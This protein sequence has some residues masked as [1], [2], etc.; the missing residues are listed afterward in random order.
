MN[1]HVLIG[2]EA[3][4]ALLDEVSESTT[5]EL[6]AVYG[7]RRVGKTYL[8]RNYLKPSISFEFSGIHNVTTELQLERFAK[9][10]S[11]QLNNNIPIGVLPDWFTA[12]ELFAKLFKKKLRKRTVMFLD[13][14]PWMQTAKSNFL[15]AFENFW[16]TW[17]V[18]QNNLIVVICGSAA[19]WMIQNVVRNKGGLHNRITRKIA[20]QPF[21]LAETE[22]FL[23][24]KKVNLNRYQ[25]IQLYMALGGIPHYLNEAKPGLSAAQIIDKSC[26]SRNG[27]LY[28]EFTD[29]YKALFDEAD[30]HIKV[31]RVLA[32]KPM[33]LTRNQLIKAAKL[34][35]GG[36]TTSLLEELSAAGFITPYIPFGKKTKDTIYKLTDQFSLFYLKFMEANRSGAKGTWQR[37]SDTAAWKSWSGFAFETTCLKHVPAMKIAM[38]INGTH[39]EASIWRSKKNT[40]GA[41]IDLVIN[42]RD[43]CINLC[44]IKF[45]EK[46][47]SIDKKYAEALRNKVFAFIEETKTRKKTFL[48]FITAIGLTHNEHSLGLA[49]V[50]LSANDLFIPFNAE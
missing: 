35:T 40:G 50:Q 42:R 15:A 30:R 8:L 45:Y 25:I 32:A 13:E 24:S 1:T 5:A 9:A 11:N 18:T 12:F 48:T 21:T 14:F 41:Q 43:N 17:A 31:I 2:R 6:M 4:K 19:G 26:F 38:G 39:T 37:Q 20:L 33:G 28:N 10:V 49:E 34:Q 23:Q 3:E 22:L 16:N 44:E 27:F 29:L 47:F 36:S 7:R 46:A